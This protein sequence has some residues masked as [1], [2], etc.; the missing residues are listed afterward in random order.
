MSVSGLSIMTFQV[1]IINLKKEVIMKTINLLLVVFLSAILF[2]CSKERRTVAPSDTN[3]ID[4]TIDGT[5]WEPNDISAYKDEN[6]ISISAIDNNYNKINILI[7][8]N[9]VGTYET[10]DTSIHKVSYMDGD[11]IYYSVNQQIGTITISEI[12]S[13]K[14][15]AEFDLSV[16]SSNKN[17]N[18]IALVNSKFHYSPNNERNVCS[19]K[20]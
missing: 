9:D 19:E 20:N 3:T 2:N 6:I 12:S 15:E 7:N 8:A 13:S 17:I 10:G 16:G 14:I 1:P 11:S 4:M 18:F 5:D